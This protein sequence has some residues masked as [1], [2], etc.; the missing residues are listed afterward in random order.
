MAEE[1]SPIIVLHRDTGDNEN[2]VWLSEP[3]TCEILGEKVTFREYLGLS[4][5]NPTAK[6][7]EK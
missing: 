7:S 6:F 1:K 2:R 4:F 3:K 5:I